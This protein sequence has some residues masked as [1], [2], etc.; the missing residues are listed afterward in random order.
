MQ[1][2]TIVYMGEVGEV[3]IAV[4]EVSPIN[5]SSTEAAEEQSNISVEAV[6]A[7]ETGIYQRGNL[8]IKK[9]FSASDKNMW[10]LR[11]IELIVSQNGQTLRMNDLLPEGWTIIEDLFETGPYCDPISN[12]IVSP[13]TIFM[14]AQAKQVG[15]LEKTEPS[16]PPLMGE[17]ENG[18]SRKGHDFF[19]LRGSLMAVLHEIGHIDDLGQKSE[20]ER[21]HVTEVKARLHPQIPVSEFNDKDLQDYVDTIY[22]SERNAWMQA[23]KRY[24]Q[25]KKESGIDLAEGR[26]ATKVIQSAHT[27]LTTYE[28]DSNRVL[29]TYRNTTRKQQPPATTP[30]KVAA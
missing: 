12:R 16:Q 14:P 2:C 23:F 1:N 18:E 29:S 26:S 5:T 11:A 28:G 15:G 7:S 9:D 19:A 17:Q 20:E 27:C 21:T 30:K 22:H 25:I 8:V 24:R 4:N 6:Q 3:S 13:N 10:P